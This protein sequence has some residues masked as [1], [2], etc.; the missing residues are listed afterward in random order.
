MIKRRKAIV[1]KSSKTL[2][3]KEKRVN[4]ITTYG[5]NLLNEMKSKE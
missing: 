4:C 3:I 2:N 1:E 5:L